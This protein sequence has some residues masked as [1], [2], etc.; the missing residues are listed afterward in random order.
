MSGYITHLNHQQKTNGQKVFLLVAS[1]SGFGL[2]FYRFGW[3][4][5][6]P[7]NVTWLLAGLDEAQHFLGWHFFRHE[8]WSFPPGLI[9]G[10]LD[11]LGTSIGY[12]DSVPLLAFVSKVFA[13]ALP[14][15]SNI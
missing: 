10:Y 4:A 1:L 3:I 8:P 12:T 15:R 7:S 9:R 14:I 6:N 13:F 11:P 2:A 5:L